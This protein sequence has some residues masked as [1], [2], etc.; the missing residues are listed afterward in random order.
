MAHPLSDRIMT[1]RIPLTKDIL[2]SASGKIFARILL[3]ILSSHI[4]PD[5]VPNTQCGFR[6]NRIIVD[7]IICR[8][9]LQ[10]KCIE[11]DRPLYIVFDDLTNTF[12]IVGM[13]RLWQQRR[14]YGCPEKFTIMIEI[15]HTGMMVNVR[16]GGVVSDT[17]A[18]TNG[19]KQGGVL[20]PTLFSI[21]LSAMLE[22][23]F[24]DMGDGVYI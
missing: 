11:Q 16:N 1:M 10:E 3:N 8:R 6:S 19:V 21:F 5:V 7:M 15:L 20:A 14:K 17:F 12:D 22:E 13:T 9:Q 24:R 18:I 2:L 23:A 4:T